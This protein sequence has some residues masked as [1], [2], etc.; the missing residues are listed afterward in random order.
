MNKKG[1]QDNFVGK[2]E[3]A[4]YSKQLSRLSILSNSPQTVD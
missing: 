3:L 4:M 1:K 2:P